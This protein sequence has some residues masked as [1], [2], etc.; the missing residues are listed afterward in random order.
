VSQSRKARLACLTFP[1]LALVLVWRAHPELKREPVLVGGQSPDGR[2]VVMAASAP[3]WAQGVRPGQDWRRAEVLCPLGVRFPADPE[4]LTGLRRIARLALAACSPLVEW[5]GDAGAYVDL[6]GSDPLRPQEG[7]RAAQCGRAIEEALGVTPSVGVGPSRFSA[8]VAAQLADPGRVRLVPEG[9]AAE[10]LANWPVTELPIPPQVAER[11]VQ[12]GLHTCGD[13]ASITMVELQ[14]QFGPDGI[15][16]HRLCRGQDSAGVD[17]WRE[18]LPCGVR[19]VLAGGVDDS[20][21][22]RFGAAELARGLAQELSRQGQAAGRIRLLLRGEDETRHSAQADRQLWWGEVAPPT[23]MATA[24]ELMGPLLS[25]FSKACL[26]APVTVVEL[27][28]FDLVAPP[29]NQIGL[30]QGRAADR[31]VIKRAVDRLHDRF[32]TGLVWRVEVRPGHPGDVPEER[33]VWNSR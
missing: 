30:W 11:L 29:V 6:A 2:Q 4:A 19:R 31:E 28:A 27:E 23:P 32:G 8:W 5:G 17:P 22:L 20:E 13:C 33:L 15:L 26:L 25:L 3:A 18:A 10:F 21:S 14:R 1:H 12:F 7:L 16:I 24:D 9:K